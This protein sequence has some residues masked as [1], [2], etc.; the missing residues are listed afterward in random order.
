[1]KGPA[2][3][4]LAAGASTRMGQP[5]GLLDYRGR[6]WLRAQVEVIRNQGFQTIILVLGTDA[7]AYNPVLAGL[8]WVATRLNKEP[9]RGPFSSLLIGLEGLAG[10][11][12]IHPIDVPVPGALKALE[13]VLNQG[14][15]AVIPTFEG[16]GGHPV[17]LSKALIQRLRRVDPASPGARLDHQ[18]GLVPIHRVP[19]VDP[20]V[21][22][23]LNTP[24]AWITFLAQP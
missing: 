11:A 16:R 5:K 18:L 1:M 24:E 9:E 6:P 22:L 3:V 13:W 14:A 12:W 21:V 8:P 15:E 2:F 7:N 23:N 20:K 17:L 19:V 10:P 4:L